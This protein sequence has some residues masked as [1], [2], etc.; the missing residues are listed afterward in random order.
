M[1]GSAALATYSLKGN[2]SPVLSSSM[3][4]E[5]QDYGV[6]TSHAYQGAALKRGDGIVLFFSEGVGFHAFSSIR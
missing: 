3:G 4:E 5:L 1:T 2:Q 6:V